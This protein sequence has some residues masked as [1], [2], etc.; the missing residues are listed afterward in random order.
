MMI[1]IVSPP[2]APWDIDCS[3]DVVRTKQEFAKDCD[4]NVIIARCL[5]SGMPLPSVSAAPL[6]ADVSE[7]G[8]YADCIRRVNAAESAFMELPADIRSQFDN[9]PANI[10]SFLA[11]PAN[12]DQAIAI[13]L[14]PKPV[15]ADVALPDVPAQPVPVNP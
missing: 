11:D 13:G 6:Y 5:K 15:V 14:I 12:K 8:S 3:G 2:P 9:E 4:V 7:V 1:P 10:I